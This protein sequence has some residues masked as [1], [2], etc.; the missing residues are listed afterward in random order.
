MI[1]LGLAVCAGLSLNLILQFALG[2]GL[3]GQRKAIPLTQILILFISSFFLWVLYRYVL[4]F[5]PWEI[6]GFLLLFPFS[7]LSCMGLEHLEERLFAEKERS[8]F[9]SWKTAYEGIVPA[10]TIL[11]VHLS[12]TAADAL[13]LSFFF[14][15]GCLLAIIIMKEINRRS[16]LESL[17]K[18]FRGIP[19]ALIS[20]GLLSM[21]FGSI[22]WICYRFLNAF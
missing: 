6:L 3:A 11:C 7:A 15:F 19:V 17:P 22:A 13:F 18:Y 1:L 4:N 12:V 9:F 20:M 21:V 8:R 10:S 14:A 2:A 5:L 16:S